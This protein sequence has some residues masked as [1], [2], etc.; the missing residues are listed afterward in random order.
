MKLVALLHNNLCYTSD[1]IDMESRCKPTDQPGGFF[2]Q[3]ASDQYVKSLSDFITKV[4]F[5]VEDVHGVSDDDINDM[6]LV[7]DKYYSNQKKAAHS[8]EA[9]HQNNPGLTSRYGVDNEITYAVES[10]YDTSHMQA[11]IPSEKGEYI[12]KSLLVFDNEKAMAQLSQISD[13]DKQYNKLVKMIEEGYFSYLVDV[14][15]KVD[16]VITALSTYNHNKKTTGN[17]E[18]LDKITAIMEQDSKI[19]IDGVK[20]NNAF[21]EF[22]QQR[23]F[24]GGIMEN[25]KNDTIFD[26]VSHESVAAFKC[27]IDEQKIE[28]T[29][30]K[31]PTSEQVKDMMNKIRTKDEIEPNEDIIVRPK[32]KI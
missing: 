27:W 25:C 21:N 10:V 30:H 15:E 17:I 28:A 24:I 11:I 7:L 6:Y 22:F 13:H 5:G 32:R 18:V 12:I 4:N 2:I 26:E 29:M 14:S 16:G 9:F 31:A 19:L 20:N 1:I 3:F 23:Q 8:M